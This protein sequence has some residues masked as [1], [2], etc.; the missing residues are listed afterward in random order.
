MRGFS[1]ASASRALSSY[2][3]NAWSDCIAAWTIW[4]P[5][6]AIFFSVPLW[7]RLPVNHAMSFA[8]VCVLSLSRG[9]GAAPP[10]AAATA[11]SANAPSPSESKTSGRSQH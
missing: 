10:A 8:Y 3:S 2:Y 7:L 4:I 6:H 1:D 9:R 11:T 5:G